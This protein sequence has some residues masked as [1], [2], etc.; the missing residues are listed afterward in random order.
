ME[1]DGAADS[2]ASRP[3]SALAQGNEDCISRWAR[4][5]L[6]RGRLRKDAVL[7]QTV[8]R[9]LGP[10]LVQ[11]SRR[12]RVL[13]PRN[14]TALPR[15]GA[16]DLP[17]RGFQHRRRGLLPQKGRRYLVLRSNDLRAKEE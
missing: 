6:Q 12:W 3:E 1:R 4:R 16:L 8:A 14:G 5:V 10:R 7:R 15:S 2:R 11:V 17:H 13:T 9:G